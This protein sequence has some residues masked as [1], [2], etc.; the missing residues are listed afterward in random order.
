MTP[1]LQHGMEFTFHYASTLSE[2]DLFGFFFFT[3]IYIPLCFYFI[4]KLSHSIR[5]LCHLHSTM[6]LL[7]PALR[8]QKTSSHSHL[9]STMLLLYRNEIS[10]WHRIKRIYIPL[11]FYFIGDP[12]SPEAIESIHLHSTMLLLYLQRINPIEEGEEIYIP[13]CFYFIGRSAFG[14]VCP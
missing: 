13:L 12:A 3:I 5:V 11:C 14:T 10:I 7:Y 8:H 1:P 6:L 2:A 4:I 9:H